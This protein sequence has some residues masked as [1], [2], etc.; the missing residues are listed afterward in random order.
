MI[1]NLRE[2][3][4]YRALLLS[5]ISRDL[6]VRY[7]GSALGFL[8]TFINP[9]ILMAIYTIVFSVYMRSDLKAYPYF[10]LSGL[11][12]WLWFS[13]S[14]A[15]GASSISDRRDL[16]SKVRFPPQIL[17]MTVIGSA[18][19]NYIFS[20]P[21][22]LV[23]AYGLGVDVGLPLIAFPLIVVAQLILT[24]GIAYFLAS[25]NVMFRDLQHIVPNIVSFAFFLTP[26]IYP[27]KQI[28]EA[29][30]GYALM[31][32]VAKLVMAYQDIFYYDRWPDF[33]GLLKVVLVGV[34]LFAVGS[35]Y[36][37]RKREDFAE[38]A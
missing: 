29:Y 7:R 5:L 37:S 9:L 36:M 11:L 30:R 25:A 23:F 2:L 15:G 16:I 24:G 26:I 12:P 31:N 18:M 34:V 33:E 8:W 35:H 22:L 28:P 27:P 19:M 14:V 1:E 13:T 20:L 38:V 17:P 21:I 3:Y 10:M 6:K 4:Q 32:P